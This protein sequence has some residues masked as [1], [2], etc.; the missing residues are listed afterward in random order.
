LAHKNIAEVIENIIYLGLPAPDFQV[1]RYD[2]LKIFHY[3]DGQKL[4]VC[5]IEKKY[6]NKTLPT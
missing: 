4:L 6:K 2:P 1:S 5:I 3:L